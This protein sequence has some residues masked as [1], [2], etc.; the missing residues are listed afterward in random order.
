MTVGHWVGVAGA[1]RQDLPTPVSPSVHPPVPP[2]VAAAQALMCH[3]CKDFG[4]CTRAFRCP[5]NSNYCVTIATRVPLSL[6]DLPMVTKSCQTS[7]PDISTLGLGPHVSIVC[8]Q[9][10]LCNQD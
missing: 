1:I 10:S 3:Q 6:I 7:C 2:P 4:G 5:R 8:C 9:F